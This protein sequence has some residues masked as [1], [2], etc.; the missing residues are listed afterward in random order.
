MPDSISN[1]RQV[2]LVINPH[3]LDHCQASWHVTAIRVRK[4]IPHS[5]IWAGGSILIGDEPVSQSDFWA[6]LASLCA[7]QAARR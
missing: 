4:G 6:A 7:E 3:P 2:R 1:Y 5:Q